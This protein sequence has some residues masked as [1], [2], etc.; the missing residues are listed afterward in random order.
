MAVE[1]TDPKTILTGALILAGAGGLGH[2]IGLTVEP[3]SVTDLRVENARLEARLEVME[4]VV[5]E[6]NAVLSL[7]RAR[8]VEAP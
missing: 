5:S 7:A 8:A 1:L 4:G 2:T 3:A 6:C